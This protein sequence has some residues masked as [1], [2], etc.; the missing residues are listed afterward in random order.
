MLYHGMKDLLQK[1][2]QEG[3]QIGIV[4]TK[5]HYRI[6]Q[7]L[8]KFQA[9]DLVDL[10]VGAEDIKIEKP[11]PEGLLWAIDRLGLTR[12]VLYVGDSL[13]DAQTA[14]NAQVSFVGGTDGDDH[15]RRFWA[16]P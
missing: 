5:F 13:V 1:L 12:Q 4:T 2:R 15:G 16:L 11:D 10:V 14:E 6:I 3:Y 8:E 9:T 7:I